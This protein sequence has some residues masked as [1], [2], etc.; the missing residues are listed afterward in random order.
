MDGT[1]DVT[2]T[3]HTRNP[4]PHQKE[5]FT[6]VLKG[7]IGLD[8][9]IFPEGTPGCLLDAYAREH[10]WDVGKD[11]IHGTGHGVGAALNVHEGPQRISRALD[12][13]PL[14]AGMVVS[15]E[16]GYYEEGN[17]GIRIENLLAVVHKPR[18]GMYAGRSFLGFEKLTL[19]PIQHKCIDFALFTADE[20]Q[21]LD[22]YHSDIREKLAPHIQSER[23]LK[24]LRKSTILCEEYLALGED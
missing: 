16:P 19:I 2:R 22:E 15:N 5:M 11:Y 1:T 10:L 7:N 9:R 20:R 17:F 14:E 4:A 13:Q 12:K 6:R 3:F 21:W 23:G 24:W 8:S 18:K